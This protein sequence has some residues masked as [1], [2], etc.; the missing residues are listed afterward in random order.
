MDHLYELVE[1]ISDLLRWQQK[2]PTFRLPWRTS[3]FPILSN[4]SP[5]YLTPHPPVPLTETEELDLQLALQRL[6]SIC[7]RCEESNIPLLIDAEY[8]TVQPA[9]DYFTYFAALQFNRGDQPIVYGTFQ[10]YLRDSEQRMANGFQ[11]AEEAGVSLGVKLVRGAYLTRETKLALSLDVPS[12]IHGSIHETHECFNSC[13]SF[14]LEKVKKGHGAVVLAT[15]NLESG[16]IAAE[17]AE[18]L[19]IGKHDRKLQFAQLMGMADGLSLGLRNAGFYVSKYLPFGPVEQVLP[20]LLRR[21]EENRG[22]V[23]T[24]SIDRQLLRKELLRRL[25][26]IVVGRT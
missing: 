13:A 7:K 15:H 20:Y 17:K 6:S 22:F 18:E 24:S 5:L 3:S 23:S 11:A 19:R 1:R 9:I 25:A 21:A 12:P 26:T 8:L 10:T 4:S 2:N 14:M 16:R